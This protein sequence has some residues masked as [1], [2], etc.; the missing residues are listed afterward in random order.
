MR[1]EGPESSVTGAQEVT[2]GGKEVSWMRRWKE[3]EG[4]GGDAVQWLLF[5]AVSAAGERKGRGI[6]WV[7]GEVC[8]SSETASLRMGGRS[9]PE[10]RGCGAAVPAQLRL[11]TMNMQWH[12]PV[13]LVFPSSTQQSQCREGRNIA[14]RLDVTEGKTGRSS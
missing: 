12:Q 6:E 14:P 7:S 11:E 4:N 9:D 1:A 2:T 3:T 13:R 5:Q 8:R 10:Q